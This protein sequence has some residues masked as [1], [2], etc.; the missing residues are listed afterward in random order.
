MR[1]L[2]DLLG[3]QYFKHDFE[4]LEYDEPEYDTRLGL[5]GFHRVRTRV[6]ALKREPVLPPEI[7]A[8]Y[9]RVFWA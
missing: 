2:Y 4:H 8:Q 1:C 5:P 3:E 9:D 6:E 7:F